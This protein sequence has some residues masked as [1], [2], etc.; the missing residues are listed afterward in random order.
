MCVCVMVS[1]R[2]FPCP[3]PSYTPSALG[4]FSG[5]FA[6]LRVLVVNDTRLPW[7][8]LQALEVHLP[9]LEELHA[10]KNG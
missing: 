10:C 8:S 5:A 4:A 3:C 7:S 1:G 6:N 9:L 2:V